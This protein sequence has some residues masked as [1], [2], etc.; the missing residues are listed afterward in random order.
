MG[1]EIK[2][3][4]KIQSNNYDKTLNKAK[5]NFF[6]ATP[7]AEE[8][9]DFLLAFVK[10]NKVSWYPNLVVRVACKQKIFPIQS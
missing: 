9:S 1:V 6:G 2:R 7:I 5:N 10:S 4:Q 3:T 8:K